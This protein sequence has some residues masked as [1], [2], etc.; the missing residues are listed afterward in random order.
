MAIP[1]KLKTYLDKNKIKH[2][3]L[4]H[5]T[6]YTVFD[7][8]KTLERKLEGLAKTLALKADKSYLLVV[9][10][11]S[12]RLDLAKLKKLLKVKKL[13]IVKETVLSKIFKVK[14][15][16]QVP[17]GTFHRVPVYIDRALLKN[18][19]IIVGAGSYTDSLKLAARDLLKT[20]GE[21]LISFSKK[22]K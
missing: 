20:G 15:G 16:N 12:R 22:I 1:K 2:E 3:V 17:F 8:A 18:K 7:K 14:P 19:A 4:S 6:V 5:K 13:E 9:V 21:T 10:P 11:A